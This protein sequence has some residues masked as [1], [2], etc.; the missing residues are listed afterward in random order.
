MQPQADTDGDGKLSEEEEAALNKTILKRFPQADADG[1]G[2][3]SVEE[4]QG[5][6]PA[7]GGPGKAT[8]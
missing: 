4:Q 2:A 6:H 8:R 3:L 7:S 1:D 5:R